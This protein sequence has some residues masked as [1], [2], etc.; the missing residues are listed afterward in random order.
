MK[1]CTTLSNLDNIPDGET[2]KI[3]N[4]TAGD[5]I[6]IDENNVISTIDSGNNNY[7]NLSNK[8]SINGVVLE[9]NK[10]SEDLGI[11]ILS[12][13]VLYENTSGSNSKITLSDSAANYEYLEIF[14][15]N[16][17]NIYNSVKVYQPNGKKVNLISQY[18]NGSNTI[19]FKIAI[20]LISGNTITKD[21]AVEMKLAASNAINASS[22]NTN[23]I[24]RVIGYK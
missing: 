7:N 4:Y 11:D 19:W 5:G 9:G 24:T 16:N 18:N 3:I 13:N 15:R 10:T 21:N 8:P 2:R 20:C 23:Y 22:G 14:F 1:L 17:D 6:V 12:Q